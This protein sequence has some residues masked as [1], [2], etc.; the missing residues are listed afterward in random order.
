MA[1][2]GKEFG[3]CL[4]G[5][6][7]QEVNDDIIKFKKLSREKLD[8]VKQR[9]DELRTEN[10]NLSKEI[11]KLKE[12]LSSNAQPE[13]FMIFALRKFEEWMPMVTQ[14]AEDEAV[15]INT[16]ANQ[17]EE[18][19]NKKIEEFNKEIKRTQ[20]EL[21]MLLKNILKHTDSLSENVM[22]F[23]HGSDGQNNSD[24]SEENDFE[25]ND[26]ILPN[27]FCSDEVNEISNYYEKNNLSNIEDKN[28]FLNSG[29]LENTNKDAITKD[30]NQIRSKYLLGKI[31]GEDLYDKNN[32]LIIQK[33]GVITEKVI[34]KAIE[35]GKLAELIINMTVPD[36][37]V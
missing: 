17:Q 11:A 26:V 12:E 5:Y 37:L 30:I 25:Y 33:H 32:V 6:S 2:Q 14:I 29:E 16:E 13:E 31:A 22:S 18:M 20:E 36:S 19:F 4:F 3:V 35:K 27:D 7:K 9:A 28:G 24:V 15:E 23:I 10:E 34:E 21:D 1:K 8:A